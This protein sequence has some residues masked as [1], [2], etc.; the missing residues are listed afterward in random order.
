MFLGL[1][2]IKFFDLPW[3]LDNL[4]NLSLLWAAL[5]IL[6]AP[7]IIFFFRTYSIFLITPAF[8][9]ISYH[10]LPHYYFPLKQDHN[11]I[12]KYHFIQANLSYYN[13]QLEKFL[14]T[15][16]DISPD[17]IFLFEFSD[18]N[19]P[20]FKAF[21][22]GRYI[23]GYEEIQGFPSGIGVISKYPIVY[24]HLHKSN[25]GKASEILEIKF[26]DK[27][28]D[29][30]IHSFLLHPPSPRTKTNWQ[31]RNNLLQKLKSL[32]NKNQSE[33]MLVAGDINISPWSYHFP[34]FNKFKACYQGSKYFIS[35]HLGNNIPKSF[36]LPVPPKACSTRYF[37]AP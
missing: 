23:Y 14:K 19:K 3:W 29:K 17:F 9:L 11:G 36:E 35:W 6:V 4:S 5:L 30:I 8:L 13:T 37:P 10:F 18:R 26:Y 16:K 21:A 15:T 33:Y 12:K 20:L 1:L 28:L 25:E 2:T 27:S 32:I 22:K 7:F 24:S 31:N 34:K